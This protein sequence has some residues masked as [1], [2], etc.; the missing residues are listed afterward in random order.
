MRLRI[1]ST[2]NLKC[3]FPPGENAFTSHASPI[4]IKSFSFSPIHSVRVCVLY[5]ASSVPADFTTSHSVIN[6]YFALKMTFR[7]QYS[8]QTVQRRSKHS[9]LS[10]IVGQLRLMYYQYEVTFSPYVMTSG[11]KFIMN[12][13]VVALFSLL[14]LTFYSYLLPFL[15]RASSMLFWLNTESNI[16]LPIGDVGNM[17]IGWKELGSSHLGTC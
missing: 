4:E 14:V 12:C 2:N 10:S 7:V 11:E 5:I 17:T 13:I 15:A 9:V 8:F 6:Q 1:T 16:Q 3:L